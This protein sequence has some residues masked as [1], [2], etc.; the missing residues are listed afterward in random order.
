MNC[1]LIALLALSA[2]AQAPFVVEADAAGI[3][4]GTDAR[5]E[6]DAAIAALDG[7]EYFEAGRRLEA[8]AGASTNAELWR[9]A[10]AAWFEGG[11]LDK[12]DA[13][14]TTG[15]AIRKD[16]AELLL[17]QGAVRTEQGR[18]KEAQVA[19]G[20]AIAAAP[21]DANVQATAL[22]NRGLGELEA[23]DLA[24]ARRDL[25]EAVTWAAKLKDPKLAQAIQ[26]QRGRLAGLGGPS[27]TS[28]PLGLVSDALSRGDLAAARE[29]LPRVPESDRRGRIRALI[30]EAA[31]AR[32]E[33]RADAAIALLAQAVANAREGGLVREHAAAQ[34]EL[35]VTYAAMGQYDL[36][37]PQL[38]GAV[39]RVDGTG[40]K[41][42]TASYHASAGVVAAK[43]G[44]VVGAKAHLAK[45]KA[46]LGSAADLSTRARLDELAGSLAGRAG[47][48]AAAKAAF[49]AATA[50]WETLR[51]WEDAARVATSEVELYTGRDEAEATAAKKRALAAFSRSA[52]ALG[53]A[54]VALA[55]ATG[56]SRAGDPDGTMQALSEALNAAEA[57]GGDRGARFA[58]V[59]EQNARTLLA[60][61]TGDPAL[62]AKAQ[63][64]GF[65]EVFSTYTAYGDAT[66]AFKAGTAAYESKQYARAAEQ[67]DAAYQG[68]EALKEPTWSREARRNRAWANY[69]AAITAEKG[70]QLEMW[71]ATA[72]EGDALNEPEL[73]ARS[74]AGAAIAAAELKKPDAKARLLA[75][76]K[77]AEAVGLI[78]VAGRCH[79]RRVDLETALPDAVAAAELAWALTGGDDEG[80]YA[81]YSAAVRAYQAEQYPLALTLAERVDEQPW[82]LKGAAVEVRD[83]AR[84]MLAQ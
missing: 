50:G 64:L 15:L 72:K 32:A 67:F 62:E 7:G 48:V 84:S 23:G 30:G 69:N 21:D 14:A 20:A 28:D 52:N 17:V 59:A 56:R 10:A 3:E 75:A 47:D 8:L 31:I 45:G 18:L 79:A 46:A 27:M 78:A 60:G 81:V 61:V 65:E 4:L 29:A 40:F 16:L 53:P 83:A 37:R 51:A 77:A 41:L 35:G 26:E 5:A 74:R 76:S 73:A 1:V 57:V 13:A 25:D 55:E 11:Q 82:Q 68:F 66:T 63:G 80:K 49:A 9:L 43:L 39:S 22:Y 33:G 24:G 54:W 12:A 71:D 58:A 42:A 70:K 34:S 2:A 6:V 38:E 36:A 44:D 19:L